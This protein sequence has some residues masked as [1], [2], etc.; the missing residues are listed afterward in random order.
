MNL[1]KIGL[2]AMCLTALI[3]SVPA[4]Q[5]GVAFADSNAGSCQLFKW[6]V[7]V[8]YIT[9]NDKELTRVYKSIWAADPRQAEEK[10]QERFEAAKNPSVRNV[11]GANAEK[12]P[13]Q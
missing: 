11:I 6:D 12:S 9:T 7:T 3:F 4:T 13:E 5:T 8:T 2:V 10:A 1:K